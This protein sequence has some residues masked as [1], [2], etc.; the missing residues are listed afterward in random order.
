MHKQKSSGSRPAVGRGLVAFLMRQSESSSVAA[1][2]ILWIIFSIGNS[3]FNTPYN[4]FNVLRTSSENYIIAMSQAFVIIVGGMN[5]SIGGIGGISAITAGFCMSALHLSPLV[6]IL[7]SCVISICCGWLN[8][9]LI[10]KLKINA[11]IVTL[12]TSFIFSGLVKGLT[13]GFPFA[14]I[15]ESFTWIAKN[16]IGGIIP[17]IFAIMIVSLVFFQI[18]FKRSVLGRELLATG[19]SLEA[20]KMSGINTNRIITQANILSGLMA[21]LAGLF[22]VARMAAASPLIGDDWMITSFAVA[23]IG[24]TSLT[25]GRITMIGILAASILITIIKNGLVMLHANVYYLNSFLGAII[26][27]AVILEVFREK[28]NERYKN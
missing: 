3:S 5:V 25:G 21:G 11:F 9:L 19:G 28:Y 24:G 27:A 4:I 14:D 18:F 22:T 23:V 1:L 6:A 16:D 10:T 8:G 26:I 7:A 20:A 2:V 12:A 17:I 15:P 13:G